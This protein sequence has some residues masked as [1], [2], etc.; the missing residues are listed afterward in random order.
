MSSM[1]TC[2]GRLKRSIAPALHQP[3]CLVGTE[4]CHLTALNVIKSNVYETRK[5]NRKTG[6]PCDKKITRNDD[7]CGALEKRVYTN[8]IIHVLSKS[9]LLSRNRCEENFCSFTR[10]SLSA[11]V[12]TTRVPKTALQ[13]CKI[14]TARPPKYTRWTEQLV[15]F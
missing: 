10:I 11:A 8:G 1:A 9:H 5:K 12:G 7:R 3:L 14:M 13:D 15:N 4:L 2:R 6:H